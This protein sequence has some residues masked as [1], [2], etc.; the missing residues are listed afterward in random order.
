VLSRC[1]EFEY[2]EPSTLA[3]A[4]TLL[5]KYGEDAKIIAGGTDLLVAMKMKGL[6]PKYIINIKSIPNLNY[7]KYEEEKGLRIGAL[8]KLSEIENS[9]LIKEKF[10]II[11]KA[12]GVIGSV[13]IR[14]LATIGG[15]ICNASPAADMIP[16]LLVLDAEVNIVGQKRE[17]KFPLV[18]FFT[19]PGKTVLGKEILS[20]VIIPNI[21]FNTKAAYVKYSPRKAMDIAQVGVAVAITLKEENRAIKK[22]RIALGGVSPTP[23][24][25][26][27]AEEILKD[28]NINNDLIKRVSQIVFDEISPI[29]DVRGS[30][31]YKKEMARTMI[32]QILEDIIAEGD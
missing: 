14:N 28:K 1:K 11:A 12:A 24:R 23:K 25:I 30:A 19:G 2:Y 6:A 27:P 13:Q 5:E 20:E 29:S 17:K 22:T 15:N 32:S 3:E 4:I 7:I 8:T 10:N 16:S 21:S 9:D 31:C 18:N 26:Y